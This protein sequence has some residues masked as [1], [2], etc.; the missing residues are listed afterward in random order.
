MI[1]IFCEFVKGRRKWSREGYPFIAIHNT[2][3]TISFLA[4][5]FPA[6]E[7][8][9]ILVIP[10]N[11]FESIEKIPKKILHELIEHATL[12]SKITRKYHKGCNILINNGRVAGQSINHIHLHVIPRDFNDGIRVESWKYKKLSLYKFIKLSE[13]IKNNFSLKQN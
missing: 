11:H 10:K 5:D 3:D 13:K 8:W 1:C 2:K 12:A 4:T 7:D 9:H 6:H